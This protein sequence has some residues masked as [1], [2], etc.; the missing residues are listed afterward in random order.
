VKV[1]YKIITPPDKQ[2]VLKINV[3]MAGIIEESTDGELSAAK[4]RT[5]DQMVNRHG[6]KYIVDFLNLIQRENVDP[7]GFG[8]RYKATRL[9]T[10]DTFAEWQ[11]IYPKIKFDVTVDTNLKSTGTIE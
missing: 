8:L 4:L 5:Y 3:K 2:H 11:K 1:K 10:R 6:K 9:H 7:L